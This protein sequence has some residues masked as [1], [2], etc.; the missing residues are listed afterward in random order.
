MVLWELFSRGITPY[1]KFT[2]AEVIEQ[3]VEGYRLSKPK[4]CPDEVYELMKQCWDKNPENRISFEALVGK[5]SELISGQELPPP[6]QGI[7]NQLLMIQ[8]KN[9]KK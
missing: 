9:L 2:N 6:T 5:L 8:Q 4:D 1:Y 7:L 3:V